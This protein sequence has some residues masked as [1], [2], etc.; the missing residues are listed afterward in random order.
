MSA[1]RRQDRVHDDYLFIKKSLLHRLV[2]SQTVPEGRNTPNRPLSKACNITRMEEGAHPQRAKLLDV[3]AVRC[4][5]TATQTPAFAR[6]C[7]CERPR[8]TQVGT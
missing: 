7:H 6:R 2:A 4:I 1:V 3:H 8:S 5:I